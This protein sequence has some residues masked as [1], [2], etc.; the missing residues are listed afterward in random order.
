MQFR[1]LAY[2]RLDKNA[3]KYVLDKIQGKLKMAVG[4]AS[5]TP[6]VKLAAV[7]RFFAPLGP[8]NIRIAFES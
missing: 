1:F 5:V 8:P 4:S 7:L 6:V 2:F 3:F